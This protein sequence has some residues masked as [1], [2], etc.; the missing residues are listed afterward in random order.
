MVIVREL[1]E[2]DANAFKAL[3]LR[4]LREHP[5]AYG[6]SFEEEEGMPP[7][8]VIQRFTMPD[9]P[10]FGA[11]DG[12]HLIGVANLTRSL[13]V[14]TR[15]R[16]MLTGMYVAPQARNQGVGLALLKTALDCAK[17][18][19]D[20]E[21][22]VLA[23]TV[24]NESARHLYLKAGFVPYSVDPR[25]IRVDDR[26]YDIEWMILRIAEYGNGK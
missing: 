21:D 17:Q 24:G 6:S 18:Q 23:V 9:S 11:F 13:R 19:A 8:Q 15:H 5:E 3:R 26:Y 14:K 4:A 20:L 22:V 16:T 2:R 7:E 1:T 12:D 10:A 25:F